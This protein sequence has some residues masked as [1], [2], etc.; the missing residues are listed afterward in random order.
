MGGL[1]SLKF[2]LAFKRPTTITK[3]TLFKETKKFGK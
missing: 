2:V 3:L 1:M